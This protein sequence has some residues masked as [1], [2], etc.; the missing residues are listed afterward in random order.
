MNALQPRY[1]KAEFARRGTA[2]YEQQIRPKIEKSNHGE[3]VAIDID[4]G[5]YELGEDTLTAS[6]KLRAHHPQAQI[7]C[8]RIGHR[9]V[10]RF[11]VR[12]AAAD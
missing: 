10:H 9:G 3:I 11:G 12:P 7:W 2:M 8:V 5:A 6:E 1:D 4:S